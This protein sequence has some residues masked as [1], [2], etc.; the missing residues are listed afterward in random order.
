MSTNNKQRK[1]FTINRCLVEEIHLYGVHIEKS[2]RDYILEL[3]YNNID[4]VQGETYVGDIIFNTD[5]DPAYIANISYVGALCKLADTLIE[6][7]NINSSILRQIIIREVSNTI[8]FNKEGIDLIETK[9]CQCKEADENIVQ[10]FRRWLENELI[11][12]QIEDLVEADQIDDILTIPINLRQAPWELL[13][14]GNLDKIFEVLFTYIKEVNCEIDLCFKLVVSYCYK[15]ETEKSKKLYVSYLKLL[16]QVQQVLKKRKEKFEKAIIIQSIM[17]HEELI[18]ETVSKQNVCIYSLKN[19]HLK[20]ELYGL[21]EK[22][23]KRDCIVKDRAYSIANE[24]DEEQQKAIDCSLNSSISIITGGAGT[25][26]TY[27]VQEIIRCFRVQFPSA[28]IKIVAPTGKAMNCVKSRMGEVGGD[29]EIGT[30]HRVLGMSQEG[31]QSKYKINAELLIVDEASMVGIQN[32]L[33][34]IKAVINNSNLHIVVV[35]DTNQIPPVDSCAVLP[36][37]LSIKEIPVVRLTQIYRQDGNSAIIKNA[38]KIIEGNSELEW[39]KDEFEIHKA[40]DKEISKKLETVIRSLVDKKLPVQEIQI[41]S[42]VNDRLNGV[43]EI[44]KKIQELMTDETEQSLE[45]G[46][47]VMNIVNNYGKDVF[48]GETGIITKIVESTSVKSITVC[49][50]VDSILKE[51]IYTNNEIQDIKP[52]FCTT[53]HKMQGSEENIVILV[54]PKTHLKNLDR[55]IL[56]VAVTRAKERL[57]IVGDKNTLLQAILNNID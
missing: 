14:G 45:V 41:L 8:I 16:E 5:G 4:I 34:L 36:E 19:W 20:R 10:N 2:T 53:I 46:S 38:Y 54:I 40:T 11:I 48:N 22:I 29:I 9:V 39:V 21:I 13:I 31:V 6:R 15:K 37:L 3:E 23:Q 43:D 1:Q 28:K 26:K 30:I 47:K 57:I 17:G 25:G 32:F 50:K 12:Q 44:N 51:I 27:T 49:Y 56:Y 33:R 55:K 24:Y 35:G 7:N 18:F 42:A 52:A